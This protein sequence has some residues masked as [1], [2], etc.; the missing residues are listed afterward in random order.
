MRKN[1][2]LLIPAIFGVSLLSGCYS[3]TVD[4]GPPKMGQTVDR[5]HPSQE[6][7][8]ANR[9]NEAHEDVTTPSTVVPGDNP[10]P[11]P[12]RGNSIFD[13]G[14]A[15]SPSAAGANANTA[16]TTGTVPTSPAPASG[17]ATP[18]QTVPESSP[19]TPTNSSAPIKDGG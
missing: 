6:Q 2:P 1:Y 16:N 7:V 4:P 15:S 9:A 19:L 18:V 3:T 17:I 11:V 12:A 14:V 13:N 10:E 5:P 8:A